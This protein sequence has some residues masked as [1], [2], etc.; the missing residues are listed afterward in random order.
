MKAK[1]GN[2]TRQAKAKNQNLRN[3]GSKSKTKFNPKGKYKS[4]AKYKSEAK[5]KS[6]AK[7]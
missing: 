6:K 3:P 1:K 4:K 2:N 5:Y 7:Y